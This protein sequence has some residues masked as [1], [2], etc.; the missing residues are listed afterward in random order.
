MQQRLRESHSLAVAPRELAD[1][2]FQHFAQR[3]LAGDHVDTLGA[4]LAR[5]PAHLAEKVEQLSGR[6]V[7]V[8]RA[9]LGEVPQ[10]SRRVD[11]VR[12]HVEPGDARRAF[13][14]GKIAAE[15]LHRR[16]LPRTVRP[17]ERNNLSSGNI[18]ADVLGRYERTVVLGQSPG[19]NHQGG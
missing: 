19:L 13:V 1:R 8:E 4:L 16:G 10:A 3:A 18:E 5:K 6:H 12:S 14:R 7:I 11:P 15:N 17:Q 2:F 9:I